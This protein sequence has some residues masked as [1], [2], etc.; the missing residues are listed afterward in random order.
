MRGGC[1]STLTGCPID[2]PRL[3]IHPRGKHTTN[4]QTSTLP[5]SP[6]EPVPRALAGNGQN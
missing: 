2:C 5:P 3:I 1:E 4:V 6:P